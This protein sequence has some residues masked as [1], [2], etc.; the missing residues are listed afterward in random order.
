MVFRAVVDGKRYYDKCLI[1]AQVTKLAAE[2]Y[3]W[4]SVIFGKSPVRSRFGVLVTTR[5][6]TVFRTPLSNIRIH[7]TEK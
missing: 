1:A 5:S 2:D 3:K 7:I 4:N 6:H